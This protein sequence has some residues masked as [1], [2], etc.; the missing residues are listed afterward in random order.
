MTGISRRNAILTGS[1]FLGLSACGNGVGSDGGVRLDAR[2]DA[3]RDYLAGTYPGTR[4]LMSRA[5]GVLYVPLVTEAGLVTFGGSYGQGALRINDISVDYYSATQASVGLQI[6]A[7][8]YAHALFFMTQEALSEFRS[9]AGWV[10]GANMA[11]ALP[12]QGGS[13]GTDTATTTA[14]VIALVYG[15]AGFIAGARVTGTKY[16]RII[17]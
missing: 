5:S 3:A 16:S 17:P 1:A 8:Q 14:P 4:E 10:A 13:L 12:D 7:Q 15:Q 6:G 11:Y 9:A 2:V